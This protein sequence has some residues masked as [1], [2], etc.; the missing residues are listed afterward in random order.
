MNW[1]YIIHIGIISFALLFAAL[2]RSR[3]R[4]FQ[5]FLMPAPIIAGLI[6]LIFYN[7]ITPYWGLS[8]A[9]L[10]EMVYH[11]LNLSFIAMLLRVTPS[12]KNRV[13]GKR[14]LA[15]NVTAVMGQYGLQCTLGLSVTALLIATVKPDLFPAIGYSLPM[16]FELGPGQA[17]SIG[18]TWEKMGFVGG[19]SVGLSLAAIGFLLGSFGGVILINQGLKRGWI[20]KEYRDKINSKSVRTG[21]FSRDQKERPIGSYLSTDGESLD[22]LSYHIALVMLTYLI[23]WGFLTGLSALLSLIGPIGT[24]LADSLWGINFIFSALCAIAVKLTMRFFKVDTTIDNATC[25]RISGLSVD[26]TVASSLGAISI[27]AVQGYWL[28]I[29]ALVLAGVLATVFILP[30]YCS[31]LYDDHQFYRML[32]IYGTATGTL[33]TGLALLRVVDPDFE[34]PVA[35]DYLY[36]VGIVF[37]LAIPIILT[38]N[39]PAFSVTKGKP[40]LFW[41]ALGI[42]AIYLL[43]SFVSY[44]FLAKKKAFANAK[45]L[46]YMDN[47]E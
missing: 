37:M 42:S 8:N 34:T 18:T 25:N 29:L 23:S 7:F 20:G 24:E 41:L 6:L 32:L 46:F 44:V 16:G 11:L 33:P 38:I 1:N 19:S 10:G 30:W 22:T 5:R 13:K 43:V 14:M 9:F 40:S 2:L 28:P 36:S 35:T 3:I 4:F 15:E 45:K 31:R 12:E 27:V 39:L 26:L 47:R 17:Y 21:F